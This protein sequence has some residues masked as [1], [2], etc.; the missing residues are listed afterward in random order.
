MRTVSASE[1]VL[2]SRPMV[3]QCKYIV[4]LGR[5]VACGLMVLVAAVAMAAP[6]VPATPFAARAWDVIK[7]ALPASAYAN[8]DTVS[9]LDEIDEK[10][11]G[12]TSVTTVSRV[13]R[14]LQERGRSV[15]RLELPYNAS[16]NQVEVLEAYTVKPDGTFV[17]LERGSIRDETPLAEY[18]RFASFRFKVVD[19]PEVVPGTTVAY[20]L[21]LTEKGISPAAAWGTRFFMQD[22]QP[23]MSLRCRF[24]V[25]AKM[26]VQVKAVGVQPR[27]ERTEKT[28]GDRRIIEMAATAAPVLV[29]EPSMPVPA[30]VAWAVMGTSRESWADEMAF[31]DGLFAPAL[32]DQAG[33]EAEAKKVTAT[34]TTPL[35]KANVLTEYVAAHVRGLEVPLPDGDVQPTTA[36]AILRDGYGDAKD[37]AVLLAAMLRAVGVEAGVCLVRSRFTGSLRTDPPMPMQFNHCVVA[38]R[39]GTDVVW[40]DPAA[41][42]L[43]PGCPSRQIAGAQGLVLGLGAAHMVEIP[44][45]RPEE[46]Q[47]RVEKVLQLDASGAVQL[48]NRLAFSGVREQEQRLFHAQQSFDQLREGAVQAAAAFGPG[49]RL[50][51]FTPGNPLQLRVPFTVDLSFAVDEFATV[52]GDLMFFRIPGLGIDAAWIEPAQRRWPVVG[53]GPNRQELRATIVL[54]PGWHL[55]YASPKVDDQRAWGGYTLEVVPVGSTTV[56]VREC[57]W[58]SAA[59]VPASDWPAFREFIRQIARCTRE[60]VVFARDS[61]RKE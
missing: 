29:T 16:R 1:P 25:P 39:I 15:G 9:L 2:T 19:L 48:K 59:E 14:V 23:T 51:G 32:K 57:A 41:P 55:R 42:L 6:V 12:T 13:V 58:F 30:D 47:T 38:A 37:M 8:A 22:Q 35:D 4:C 44:A 20:C 5:A 26:P 24:D 54:P 7:G 43:T 53:Y 61:G 3:R 33:V 46:N 49:G 60:P 28:V 50:T 36:A 56:E 17:P 40:L 52:A 45:L 31:W 18:P 34:A 27:V 21:R 11:D 10:V